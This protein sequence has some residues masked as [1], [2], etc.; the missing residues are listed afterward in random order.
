ML[1]WEQYDKE[2]WG[3]EWPALDRLALIKQMEDGNY[4]C[5][6]GTVAEM[7]WFKHADTLTQAKALCVRY[8]ILARNCE[9]EQLKKLSYKL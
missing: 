4:T 9:A 7:E 6:V 2:T 3:C 8:M 1:I 5:L